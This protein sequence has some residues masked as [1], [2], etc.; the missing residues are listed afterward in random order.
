LRDERSGQTFDYSAK[1]GVTGAEIILPPGAPA[2]MTDRQQ[3]WNAVERSDKRKDAQLAREVLVSLPHELT[4]GE[5]RELVQG[6]VREHFVSRGMVA[7]IAYHAPERRGDPRNFHAH[8]M[9][10]MREIDPDQPSGFGR[11]AREWNDRKLGQE[12]RIAWERHVNAALERAGLDARVDHRSHA[13]RGDG[14][15]PEP[16]KGFVAAKMERQGRGGENHAITDLAAVRERNRE[17]REIA[18]T[19]AKLE[20]EIISLAEERKRRMQTKDPFEDRIASQHAILEI[21]GKPERGGQALYP[22]MPDRQGAGRA[23]TERAGGG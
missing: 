23:G 10:T 11:K 16:K 12:W 13:E 6:F 5:R 17:R 15:E 7:D 14:I 4:P 19:I 22:A 9:L 2:W 21:H 18:D 1:S 3:L 8:I 20:A